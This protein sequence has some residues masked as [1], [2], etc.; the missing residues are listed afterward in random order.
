MDGKFQNATVCED[1]SLYMIWDGLHPTDAFS[2]HI[3]KAFVEGAYMQ[4]PFFIKQTCADSQ[5]T[6]LS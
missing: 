5:T 3:A 4:P 6:Q 1:R 2:H